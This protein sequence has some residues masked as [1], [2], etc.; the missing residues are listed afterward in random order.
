MNIQEG[1]VI[2]RQQQIVMDAG[3]FYTSC[4][5]GQVY[6]TIHGQKAL[7]PAGKYLDLATLGGDLEFQFGE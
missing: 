2:R 4:E 6:I 7:C 1:Q 5:N 3:C